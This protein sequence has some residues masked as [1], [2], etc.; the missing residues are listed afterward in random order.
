MKKR[1]EKEN[2]KGQKDE[3]RVTQVVKRN[4]ANKHAV[5]TRQGVV[6]RSGLVKKGQKREGGGDNFQTLKMISERN[7]AGK[8]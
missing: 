3:H 5:R 8:G 6:K 4:V 1:Q 7:A 2:M